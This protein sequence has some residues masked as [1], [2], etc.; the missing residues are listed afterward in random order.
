M[1][2]RLLTTKMFLAAFSALLLFS[3]CKKD[4]NNHGSDPVLE[5]RIASV[6]QD[7]SNYLEFTYAPDG[8]LSRV[9]F[10]EEETPGVQTMDITYGTNDRIKTIY[11]N[12]GYKV[13][14]IYEDGQLTQTQTTDAT[15]YIITSGAYYYENGKLVDYGQFAPYPMEDGNEG[16]LYKRVSESKYVYNNDK[17]IRSIAT[18]IRNPVTDKLEAAGSRIYNSYDGKINPL[19]SLSDFAYGFMQELNPSNI[20]K[21]TVYDAAGTIEK[22]IER[23][24]TYDQHGYPIACVEKSTVTGQA[25]VIKNLTFT[26]Q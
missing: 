23:T 20:T 8:T 6:R 3:S 2:S 7:A 18:K 10:A 19:K 21:E 4:K 26:Y 1:P 15:G 13:D 11:L 12:D 16:V 24:Y 14:Y 5:K 25:P 22:V 9:K 17:S